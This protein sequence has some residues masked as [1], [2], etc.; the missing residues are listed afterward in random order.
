MNIDVIAKTEAILART[1]AMR[2]RAADQRAEWQKRAEE[3]AARAPYVLKNQ[4]LALPL[5]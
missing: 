3:K 2:E 5:N 4:Q 1:R